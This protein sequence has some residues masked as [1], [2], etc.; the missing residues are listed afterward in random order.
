MKKTIEKNTTV[1]AGKV[2]LG[3]KIAFACGDIF[4]GGSFNVINFLF[5]EFL[6]LVVG[7]PMTS[8]AVVLLLTKIWDGVID[9]FIGKITDGKTPGRLGKRRFFMLVA[10]PF[11]LV[12]FVALF[13]PWNIIP[14]IADNVPVKMF[15][16]IVSYMFYATAQSLV[17][18]P[19]YSHASEMTDDYTERNKVNALRLCFSL[20]SSLLCVVLPQYIARP[21][22]GDN[23]VCYIYMALAF[24]GV[25]VVSVL[26]TALFSH[27]QV[28]Y[29]AVRRKLSLREFV[30]PLQLRTYRQYLGM[31]M[32]ASM[33]MAIMSGFFY[34]FFNF[35][36]RNNSYPVL[37]ATEG[38]HF[39]MPAATIAAA[40][41]F[42]SQIIA[43]P[44]YLKL[45]KMR[46]KRFAY[47]AGA[48][49][50]ATVTAT[51]LLLPRESIAPSVAGSVVT[52]SSGTPDWLVI[53]YGFLLGF[54]ICGTVFV[55]H[56][57]FG[58]VCDVGELYFGQRTEGGFSGL[59]NFLNTTAQAIGLFIAPL[60]V[61]FAGYEQTTYAS[62]AELPSDV[63]ATLTSGTWSDGVKP[64][65][66]V[67]RFKYVMYGDMVQIQP[68]SQ[69]EGAQIGILITFTVVPIVVLVIGMIIASHFKL[70]RELQQ[71]IVECNRIADKTTE[72]YKNTREEL[73]S[74]L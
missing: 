67:D 7:L 25:F 23:G 27:E 35:Y 34:T 22:N 16:V 14:S 6:T 70:T 2:S 49:I 1:A 37:M 53:L 65:V 63:A 41:M 13:F 11:V 46:T 61:G 30:R 12:G 9:P 10:A 45:I 74:Q 47:I 54:G 17:L 19:Y 24:G 18:I 56:S 39:A 57:S 36:L 32:C 29:P 33:S 40:L 4:G 52:A 5:V 20:A 64:W 42:V 58:D 59:T 66:I 72:E 60:I 48:A 21:D 15:L 51:M 50:W 73:L 3:N 55:P 69:P 62:L 38:G 31:Q 26:V 71:R 8:L 68:I 43:M 44:F 28:V